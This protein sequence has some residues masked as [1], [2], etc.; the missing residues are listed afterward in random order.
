LDG[1]P[2]FFFQGGL[3][4]A[5]RPFF[6]FAFFIAVTVAVP[7]LGA[8]LPLLMAFAVALSNTLIWSS[9]T[10]PDS[11]SDATSANCF[12]T[13]G[14]VCVFGCLDVVPVLGLLF[15]GG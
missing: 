15:L 7:T 2:N 3:H 11:I 13:S 14:F 6:L 5:D 10:A 9:D 1:Q 4:W 8:A 12:F